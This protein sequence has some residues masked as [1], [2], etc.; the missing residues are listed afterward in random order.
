MKI[1]LCTVGTA[2]A[3]VLLTVGWT[4]GGKL[5]SKADDWA[6][7]QGVLVRALLVGAALAGGWWSYRKIMGAPEKPRAKDKDGCCH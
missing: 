3:L 1:I 2:A 4:V 5:M 7:L 6:V